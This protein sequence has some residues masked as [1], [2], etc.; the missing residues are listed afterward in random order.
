MRTLPL[1]AALAMIGTRNLMTWALVCGVVGC[2]DSSGPQQ[3]SQHG[4]VN[5]VHDA[6]AGFELAEEQQ[7]PCMLFFT[8]EW[9]T[10]CHKM[11]ESAFAD[12]GVAGLAN[13]FVCL[14]IDADREA[15]LC[16]RLGVKG[17][18]TVLFVSADGRQLHRQVGLQSAAQL[19][20]GMQTA[21]QRSAWLRDAETRRR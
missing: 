7:L 17:F 21:L 1:K 2:S 5:F 9:C 8:A 3:F 15:R 12:A 18:P 4:K 10:Y 19:A 20:R 14:L 16:R 6:A 13:H 11:E